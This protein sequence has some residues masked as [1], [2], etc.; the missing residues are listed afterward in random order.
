M[1]SSPDRF[2]RIAFTASPTPEAQEALRGLVARYGDV[3]PDA[4]DVIVALGGAATYPMGPVM[5]GAGLNVTVLSYLDN[6]DFGFLAGAEL[7]PDL[8]ELADHI[9]DAMAELLAA[10]DALDPQDAAPA[11]PV[12]A[13]PVAPPPAMRT[14]PAPS[15]GASEGPAVPAAG[16]PRR[17]RRGPARATATV[18]RAGS[19]TD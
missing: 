11:T 3:A 15:P 6:V 1:S 7:V 5:E 9:D 18:A 19:N 13:P 14:A 12:S 10:A 16:R 4:A 2:D 17:P 8:S